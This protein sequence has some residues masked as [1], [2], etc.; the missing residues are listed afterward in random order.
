VV[1]VS[2]ALILVRIGIVTAVLAAV[3]VTLAVLLVTDY[4]TFTKERGK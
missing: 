3:V 2:E 4:R 1:V